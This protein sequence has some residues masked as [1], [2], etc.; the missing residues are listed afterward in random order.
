MLHDTTPPVLLLHDLHCRRPE[1]VLT[2]RAN[3]RMSHHPIGTI[4]ASRPPTQI[5][6][7]SPDAPRT[8]QTNAE[9]CNSGGRRYSRLCQPRKS[10]FRSD[11]SSYGCHETKSFLVSRSGRCSKSWS[12]VRPV[13]CGADAPRVS[14]GV[15][16][17]MVAV[18]FLAAFRTCPAGLVV[19]RVRRRMDRRDALQQPAGPVEAGQGSGVVGAGV[20]RDDRGLAGAGFLLERVRC[21][22]RLPGVL[23]LLGRVRRDCSAGRGGRRGRTGTS[24]AGP[25]TV[26]C[27][28]LSGA[29]CGGSRP[30]ARGGPQSCG[31]GLP[32]LVQQGLDLG[33]RPGHASGDGFLVAVLVE[34]VGRFGVR[35]AQG[36]EQPVRGVRPVLGVGQGLH[37]VTYR[38][39]VPELGVDTRLGGRPGQDGPEFFLPGAGGFRRVPVSGVAGQDRAHPGGLPLG[40]PFLHCP[41]SAL[42]NL[43]SAWCFSGGGRK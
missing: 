14:S 6:P 40:Q 16:C 12:N 26:W 36:R 29:A 18:S 15:S 20:V 4:S 24:S 8:A 33:R 35:P 30:R 25:R 21:E 28:V 27:V 39:D 9:A 43:W 3:G 11:R 38:R 1:A 2:F 13:M 5:T 41:L 7:T 17:W 23:V 31:V 10:P 37:D 32:A 34:R 42:N 22:G 19:G